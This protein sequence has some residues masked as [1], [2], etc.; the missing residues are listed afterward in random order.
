MQSGGREATHYGNFAGVLA[1]S[2]PQ[3]VDRGLGHLGSLLG[4][5]QVML[6]LPEA[7]GAAAH[8]LLLVDTQENSG[9]GSNRLPVKALWLIPLVPPGLHVA[10]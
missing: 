2:D 4:L 1:S 10:I 3:L 9:H 6:D 7:D 5:V 8:L